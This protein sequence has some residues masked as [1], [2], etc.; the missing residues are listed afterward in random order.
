MFNVDGTCSMKLMQGLI[1]GINAH[2]NV[3][4]GETFTLARNEAYIGVLI[5]DLVTCG[6]DLLGTGPVLVGYDMKNVNHSVIE[7]LAGISPACG[8]TKLL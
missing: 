8:A 6:V 1:A 5:D 2:Q 4:G 3:T 7:W